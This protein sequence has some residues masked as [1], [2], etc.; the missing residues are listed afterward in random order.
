VTLIDGVR[1]RLRRG[2]AFL[3]SD[4]DD[5]VDAKEEF[6]RLQHKRAEKSA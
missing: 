4:T 6:D 2:I 5:D 1:L 3:E